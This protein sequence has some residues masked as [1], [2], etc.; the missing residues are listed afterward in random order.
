MQA[1]VT[2]TFL[3]SA[4]M[5]FEML[6]SLDMNVGTKTSFFTYADRPW[7]RLDGTA[8]PEFIERTKMWYNIKLN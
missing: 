6:E 3:E 1:P 2:W 5:N 4:M 7:V 8:D